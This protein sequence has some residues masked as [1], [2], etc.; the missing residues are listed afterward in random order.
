[1]Q[2]RIL[3]TVGTS[4]LRRWHAAEESRG[5]TAAGLPALKEWDQ[6]IRST[7]SA[8]VCEEIHT[9]QELGLQEEEHLVLLYS[10]EKWARSCAERIAAFYRAQGVRVQLREQKKATAHEKRCVDEE[11]AALC[12]TLREWLSESPPEQEQATCVLT[13]SWRRDKELFSTLSA[14]WDV[15]VY[16]LEPGQ[17]F[18]V[19]LPRLLEDAPAWQQASSLAFFRWLK[20]APRRAEQLAPW[21]EQ[22]PAWAEWIELGEDGS[23]RL[24]Q[25]AYLWAL[26]V[27]E[28]LGQRE[29]SWPP[30]EP[31]SPEEKNKVSVVS[32]RRPPGWQRWVERICEVQCVSLVRFDAP[33]GSS[34]RVKIIDPTQGWIRMSYGTVDNRLF[35]VVETTARGAEQSALV[36]RYL[37]ERFGALGDEWKS[38]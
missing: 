15:D 34:R 17:E 7:P 6:W 11:W 21:F 16:W 32:H 29:I 37:A 12:E 19:C 3:C 8:W 20:E 33:T 13:G 2:R 27:E 22:E 14:L 9:L 24:T 18:L 23:A 31:R 28:Q 35:V 26:L 10:R 36:A 5:Q 30:R 25:R 1:M 4:L 38:K